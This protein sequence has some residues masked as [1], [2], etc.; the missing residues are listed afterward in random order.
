MD[1]KSIALLKMFKER[2]SLSCESISAILNCSNSLF[3]N[4][5]EFLFTNEYIKAIDNDYKDGSFSFD[6][7]FE[8][9]PL[10]NGFLEEYS[11]QSKSKK[12][13]IFLQCGHFALTILSLIIAIIALMK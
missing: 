1:K 6:T 9:T 10:G 7:R 11:R 13:D 2:N 5:L 4:E 12:L 3:I 8:I